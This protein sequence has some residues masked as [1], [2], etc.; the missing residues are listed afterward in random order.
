MIERCRFLLVPA[1]LLA[2]SVSAWAQAAP[3]ADDR[4]LFGHLHLHPS[5]LVVQ[6]KFW[7]TLGG[8]II[9]FG[10]NIGAVRFPFEPGSKPLVK[11]L[12]PTLN[13][14]SASYTSPPTGGT[15][16]TTVNHAGFGVPN[17]RAA[18]AR[19]K[20]A[21]YPIVTRAELPP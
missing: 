13:L 19:V 5:D 8:E 14:P 10:N 15:R 18:L 9:T 2:F 20:A 1:C 17:L 21:G 3:S 12:G 4:I 11:G 7:Q 16:G 6:K